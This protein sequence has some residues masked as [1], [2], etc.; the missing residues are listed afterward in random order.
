MAQPCSSKSSVDPLFAGKME[1]YLKARPPRD[2][3]I[4]SLSD[5][6]LKRISFE[7]CTWYESSLDRL[8]NL[9]KEPTYSLLDGRR[10]VDEAP[11]KDVEWERGIK[12]KIAR[13]SEAHLGSL[14]TK[15]KKVEELDSRDLVASLYEATQQRL[16]TPHP[17][18]P[19]ICEVD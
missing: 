10:I 12:S 7:K 1:A 4:Q 19:C 5:A 16:L 13:L 14:C 3:M 11:A 17:M 9:L 18:C 15:V 6:L 8:M 2:E